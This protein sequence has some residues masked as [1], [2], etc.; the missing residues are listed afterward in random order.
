MLV[1]IVAVFFTSPLLVSADLISDLQAQ[2]Q[3]LLLQIEQ[4]KASRSS[5]LELD[6]KAKI[7]I[8]PIRSCPHIT[9]TLSVGSTDVTT[10]GQVS[11]LQLFLKHYFTDNIIVT[12]YFDSSTARYVR[13]FQ[14]QRNI[15]QVGVVGPLTRAAIARTCTTCTTDALHGVTIC[16]SINSP[17]SSDDS[18]VMPLPTSV[19][20]QVFPTTIAPGQKSTLWWRSDATSCISADFNTTT[21]RSYTIVPLASR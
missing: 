7:E 3:I 9:S 16:E 5:S 2:V 19:T 17:T 14:A 8:A 6:D 15:A 12:G 10:G 18:N 20:L 1:V 13:R 21:D 4:L 11:R